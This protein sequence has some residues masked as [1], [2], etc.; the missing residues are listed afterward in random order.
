MSSFAEMPAVTVKDCVSLALQNN[1]DIR[2]LIEDDNKSVAA[3]GME[4]GA[5]SLSVNL[6]FQPQ[7]I[8]TSSN[9]N[10]SQPTPGESFY[11]Y[12]SFSLL[13]TYPLYTPGNG[14]RIAIARKGIDVS[15]LQ[16]K[17]SRDDV[18]LGVKTLYYSLVRAHKMVALRQQMK[19]NYENRLAS[20][21]VYVQ[22][23]D[24]PVMEQSTAEVA[25]SQVCLDLMADQNVEKA[26]MAELKAQLG[27]LSDAPDL[28][29]ADFPELP[30]LKYNLDQIY[31]LVDSYSA[32]VMIAGI[33]TEQARLAVSASREQHLPSVSVLFGT[34]YSDTTVNLQK[35]TTYNTG[36][37]EQLFIFGATASLNLYSGGRISSSTDSA[38][39]DYNKSLY[40]QRK[41]LIN[42]RKTAKTNYSR[43]Q[44]LKEQIKFVHL[45][46]ENSR[47]NLLLTKRSFDSGIVNQSV[48]Q[49][50]EMTFLQSEVG[51]IDAQ[52]EYFKTL[53]SLSNLIGLEEE[54]LCGAN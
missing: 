15:K 1:P 19:T 35:M 21:K 28:L 43:L 33:K 49:T 20:V 47:T 46:I 3:Y 27:M 6:I 54:F 51:L 11:F 34:T 13:A 42:S 39:A 10:I 23:G 8:D 30:V 53:A 44:E 26:T 14:K 18:I 41:M 25:L 24:R 40:Y 45:N 16:G 17:K 22:R 38:L 36:K 48:V 29:V 5:D 37:W 9:S 52:L 7:M 4:V 2:I 50:A 32:D 12:P 31:G